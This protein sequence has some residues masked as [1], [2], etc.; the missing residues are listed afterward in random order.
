MQQQPLSESPKMN[1]KGSGYSSNKNNNIN[2]SNIIINNNVSNTT[3]NN[4]NSNESVK[5]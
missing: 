5:K 2:S 1:L 4:F 3:T